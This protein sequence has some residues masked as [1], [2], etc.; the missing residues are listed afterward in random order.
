[1]QT[2]LYI[3]QESGRK[4]TSDKMDFQD[5]VFNL[6]GNSTFIE[7]L[8]GFPQQLPK[9]QEIRKLEQTA[10]AYSEL[11]RTSKMEIFAKMVI[12]LSH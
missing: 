8:F 5:I 6:F 11:S 10:E 7:N 4:N 1:M 12:V 9:F 2:K 3:I